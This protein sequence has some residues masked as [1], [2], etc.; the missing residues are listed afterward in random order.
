MTGVSTLASEYKARHRIRVLN[1]NFRTTFVGGQVVMTA[2]VADLSMDMK[3][4]ILLRVQT[5][6][7]FSTKNDP[8]GEHDFGNFT[9]RGQKYF[10]K[11]DYYS[12]TSCTLG[13]EDPSDVT[14][15]FRVLTIMLASEY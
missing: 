9:H 10:W 8:Y 14:R 2:G 1:D 13:A 7:A 3:A 4:R 6:S 12:D 5:F 15:C 11:I